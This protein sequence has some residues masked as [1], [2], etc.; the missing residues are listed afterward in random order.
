MRVVNK[1]AIAF[2]L[3]VVSYV[4]SGKAALML[5]L[6]PG[7]ASAIFPPAGIAVAAAFIA[8]RKTLPWIFLGSLLLN[9][10]VDYSASHQVTS[11]GLLAA[12]IIAIASTFQAAAGG[13]ILRRAIGY[14]TAFDRVRDIFK[15][16]VLAPVICVVSATLS[17]SGLWWLGIF[18]TNS[19]A[20]NWLS[21]WIGDS[22]GVL[23]LLPVTMVFAG[24]PRAIWRSRLA[25]VVVPM[26]LIFALFVAMFLK[27]NQW[28]QDES[29]A[30]FR[31]ISQL[32]LSQIQ[33]KLGEQEAL[34]AEMSGLFSH[35]ATTSVTR[36][37]FQRY[38][39]SMLTRFPMVQAFE[40]APRIDASQR[41]SFERTQRKDIP[42]FEIRER[43]IKGNLHRAGVRNLYF[44]ITFVEPLSSN[45]LALG[46]DLGSNYMRLEAVLKSRTSGAVI[47]SAPIHLVQAN[48]QTGMLIMQSVK[49]NGAEIGVVLA[50]LKTQEFVDRLLPPSAKDALFVR[51][52][53]T[54][55][56]GAI[57]D[58]FVSAVP[59]ALYE[60][61]FDFG[62]RHY[63]LQTMPTAQ[64]FKQHRGWQSWG[65]L[66]IGTFGTSLL[67]ALLLLGTGYTARV[68]RQ[69]DERTRELQESKSRLK[70][71]FEN[72]SSGVAV[73]RAA[74]DGKDF[75]F[76]DFN[77]AA[78]QIDHTSREELLG[79]KVTEVFPGVERFGLLEVFMRVWRTGVAEHFP[80]TL[81]QD[82]RLSGWRENYVYKLPNGEVV[83]IFED[84]TKA[85]QA[86]DALKRSKEQ[87][88]AILNSTTESIFQVDRSGV[89]LAINEVGAHRFHKE[90]QDMIGRNAIDFFPPE[91]ATS[92]RETLEEV[93]QTGKEKHTE[94]MRDGRYFALNYYPIVSQNGKTESVVVYAA[95]ITDRQNYQSRLERL[96]VEQ[97]ALLENDLIGIVT[98]KDRAI[99]WANPAFEK[100]LGYKPG[101][102]VGKSTRVY[103]PSKEDFVAFGN[104]AY[105]F[106]TAGKIYRAQ[107]QYAHKD[108]HIIWADV[109]GTILDQE[110]GES[111]WGFLDIT[112]RKSA[113]ERLALS[114]RGADLAMTDWH[115]PSDTLT[116]GEGWMKLLGYQPGELSSHSSMLA[117][118]I[119][120]EDALLA[121]N[122]L[123]SHLKG[124]T[125]YIEAEIRMR[126]KDGHW[127]W[128][129]AR[130]MA[131]E[132]S[133][134]GRA[135]R[136]AGTAMDISSRKQAEA[137]ITRLSQ[138]SELLLNSAGEGIY[139]VD[140]AGLCTFV[141]PA[142]LNILGYT[143]DEV[144]GK[145]QHAMFHHHHTDGSNYPREECP[146]Y[147]TSQ[148]GVRREVEEAFIRKNGEIFPVQMTITP[149]HD[150]SQLVGAEVIFQDIAKRKEMELELIQ[151]ATTDSLT[152][153]ANRRHF[154]EQLDRELAH[155]KRFGKPAS[156]L[157]VD[158]DHFKNVND[159]YGHAT[160]DSV[161]KHFAQLAKL[162]LRSVDLFGRLGG[163]E[164]GILLPGTPAAGALLFAERFRQFVAETPAQSG[165]GP[166]TFTISIGVAEFDPDDAAADSIL[167]RADDA[168]YRAKEG[169]RNR[170]EV[171]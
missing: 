147:L 122:I 90:P 4:I 129:L 88:T 36:Q 145:D 32:S 91:V 39:Q 103:Y 163:E 5:A 30:E 106:L 49:I 27:A 52:I 124:E 146:I 148:D 43:D 44:P 137:E 157:M 51:L 16:L 115:I 72:L 107:T 127:I 8:G 40:W 105:P 116:F 45:N 50:V 96:L 2:L 119:R 78:E 21:W 170:V 55:E 84:V 25:T 125:P 133:A 26:A 76:T 98:V 93:C 20:S 69:V 29:L 121:R 141:N 100:M 73:Y 101:E 64:Y 153:M 143:K 82:D 109:S 74:D 54:G 150:N 31:Q 11:V 60:A 171:G 15:F 42:D 108:G 79:K 67:G 152:G 33:A 113:E 12:T 118:L 85:R 46:F 161:L 13:W 14:P 136:V 53:D 10:W 123:V 66:A 81:Y 154:L 159:T 75:I 164:F 110:T 59:M 17:V 99:R 23:V 6:P 130:G 128:V 28:E 131:V 38:T 169:G 65:V 168:L 117:S 9:T 135:V 144:L 138:W 92:R 58:N 62:G 34:L 68:V 160:G 156:F 19:L 162:R 112:D 140:R 95:D 22:L 7:Y 102:L 24:E 94:D 70:E 56:R 35:N 77:R 86:E 111:L 97:K 18:D 47:A 71:M 41:A 134:N 80:I 48:D 61:Q 155:I 104:A 83:A 149:M 126:H 139:G 63:L 158:I 166:I 89:I 167:A 114:L 132:R 57:Y 87:L 3:L 151:L 142:A 165:A 37:E 120:P 1:N